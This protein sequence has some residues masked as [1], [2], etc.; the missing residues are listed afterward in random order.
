MTGPWH[1]IVAADAP[2]VVYRND[3]AVT[4]LSGAKLRDLL[5]APEGRA[6]QTK[7]ADLI[8]REEKWRVSLRKKGDEE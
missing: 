2:C 3:L 1:L 7:L 5:G 6:L 4:D 8:E